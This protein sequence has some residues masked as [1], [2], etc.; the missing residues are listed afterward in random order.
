VSTDTILDPDTYAGIY[1]WSLRTADAARPRTQQTIEGLVGVSDLFTCMEKVRLTITETPWSNVPDT[2][3]AWVGSAIHEAAAKARKDVFPHLLIEQEL[4]ITLPSGYTILGHTDEIDPE[5]PS[6]TDL[7]TADGLETVRKHGPDHQQ[8]VQRAIYYL[9]GIQAGVLPEQ[10]IARNVWLDRSGKDK[11][12][13][14]SQ[15]PYNP[16]Y[17]AAGDLWLN[18]VIDAVKDG[19][20]APKEWPWHKCRSYCQFFTLCRGEE[21]PL[22]RTDDPETIRAAQ[23]VY[24]ARQAEKVAKALVKQAKPVLD[25][26]DGLAGPYRVHHS[27]V[28]AN[29]P[30][31]KLDVEKVA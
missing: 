16:D 24:E 25:G 27:Q 29:P 18:Q 9:G 11:T 12:P 2:T 19:S 23:D 13:F 31:M 14:V 5:E 26:F 28:N 4:R 20:Q 21:A 17:V 30:Y 10:G 7:K 15:E 1:A 3:A 6:A 8:R 22:A